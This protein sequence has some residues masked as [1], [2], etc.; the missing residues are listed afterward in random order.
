MS[1]ETFFWLA[2]AKLN[3]FLHIT[4]R[5][6][7]GY[8][9]LQSVF[10][11]L[12]YGDEISF[13]ITN[14]AEITRLTDIP[15]VAEA[16]DLIIRAARL[17]QQTTSSQHG[18]RIGVRKK[19]P[20]GGGLG[21]GSSDAATVLVMLNILW[22]TGLSVQKLAD[23]GL[24]LGADVPVFVHGVTA[25]VEGVG[26][27][28]IAIDRPEKWFLVLHPQINVSTAK[29]FTD[30]GLTRD[31][32][33]IRICDLSGALLTNVCEPIACKHYPEIAEAIQWLSGYNRSARMTGT[34]A[35]V[36]AEFD[37]QQT[38]EA[39]LQ[40]RPEKWQGFVAKGVNRSPLYTQLAEQGFVTS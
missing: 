10:Q 39:V 35:C 32:S 15:G 5:R 29:I 19:L 33:P 1:D 21:G 7:D 3:L 23:M 16:D 13:E 37:S 25:F 4:G 24:A 9:L 11:L 8:H 12:D 38:A 6:A 40:K 22:K 20:M 18:V 28:I 14:D 36:F 31:C 2:P 30:S 27:Q 17:L 26:E 34:G